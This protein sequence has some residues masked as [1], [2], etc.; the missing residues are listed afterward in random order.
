META[1]FD[2]QLRKD[3]PILNN[4][5]VVY[6]DNAAS[7]QKPSVVLEAMDH[8]Y[9]TTHANVHRGVHKL[10]Q[11]AT[12]KFESARKSVQRFINAREDAEVI[13][14]KGTTE[15]VNL[16]AHGFSTLL[17]EGDE[18]L[19]SGMEHHSNIVPWQ[20][21]CERSGAKLK[22]VPVLDD[23]SLDIGSFHDMLTDKVR[24]ISIVHVSNAL[25]TI[26]PVREIVTAAH[27]KGIP[28][29]L[30]GAQATPHFQVDVQ[31]LDCDFY[32]FSGHKV[33]GP[34]GIGVLY[35]KRQWLEKLPP[36][37]GGGEMIDRVTFE[38]TT[39]NTIPFKFEAGTPAIAEAIGLGA[40]VEY[41]QQIDMQDANRHEE[42]LRMEATKIVESIAGARIYGTTDEKCGVVSF[43]IDGIHPYDLG[44]LLDQQGIA[45]R[46][47]HHCTQPLMDRFEIPGTVRASFAFYN[48]HEELDKFSKALNRAV[49][50]LRA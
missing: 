45:V 30:D 39:Y 25:G 20:M 12:D 29:M 15:S 7:T 43:L 44:T 27:E 9:R 23:G 11:Q 10:S 50:M 32:A 36:Y 14:T 41:M 46:T 16:V 6:F 13:F 8:Y 38:K 40:A 1:T 26:N 2:M 42:E 48:T 31:A 34:T 28:V 5:A 3:F 37:Q 47:G 35:G 17:N 4:S 33:F 21:A 19:I 18:V 49:N 22:V 24:I